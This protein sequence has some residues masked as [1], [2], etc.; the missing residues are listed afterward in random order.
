MAYDR[1]STYMTTFTNSRVTYRN[2][3]IVTHTPKTVTLRS[4][5][6]ETVTTKRK[7]NQASIQFDLGYG[8]FQKDFKWFVDL[9]NGKTVDFVDGMTFSKA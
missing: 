5:G 9:P 6:Y 7:M 4:G 1:L 3:D 2:T 8:V